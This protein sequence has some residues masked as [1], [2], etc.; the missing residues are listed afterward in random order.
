MS[1]RAAFPSP[2]GQQVAGRLLIQ[3]RPTLELAL[4][5]AFVEGAELQPQA[6]YWHNAAV[7]AERGHWANSDQKF[8]QFEKPL[9][10]AK[11]A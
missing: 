1:A 10:T 4:E 11:W 6:D 7:A 3:L 8:G 5:L 2:R 9:G